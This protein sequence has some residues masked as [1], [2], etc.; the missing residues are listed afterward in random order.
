MYAATHDE[1]T[2]FG[3]P[4]AA[5][6][7]TSTHHMTWRSTHLSKAP[8]MTEPKGVSARGTAETPWRFRRMV[9]QRSRP[10]SDNK[11]NIWVSI[12]P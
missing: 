1:D 5:A 9:L 4:F 8:N 3:L 12:F 7:L 10:R 6:L 11:T 2:I